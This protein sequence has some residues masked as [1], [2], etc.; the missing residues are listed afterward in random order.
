MDYPHAFIKVKISNSSNNLRLDGRIRTS[1][2]QRRILHQQLCVL[3]IYASHCWKFE[4]L[5]L[6]MVLLGIPSAYPGRRH[7]NNN[8][9]SSEEAKKPQT[10]HNY[11]VWMSQFWLRNILNHHFKGFLPNYCTHLVKVGGE[12]M[13]APF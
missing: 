12:G 10:F 5:C 9:V 7:F 1:H 11:V 4:K 8:Q 6:R 3:R 13:Q 2:D